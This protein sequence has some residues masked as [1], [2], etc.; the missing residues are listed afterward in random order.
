MEN[1]KVVV[2]AILIYI[3]VSYILIDVYFPLIE[4]T[5]AIVRKDYYKP[6]DILSNISLT[7]VIKRRYV[8]KYEDEIYK[9]ALNNKFA[10]LHLDMQALEEFFKQHGITKLSEKLLILEMCSEKLDYDYDIRI[11]LYQT[12]CNIC[13]VE[14]LLN[15][16]DSVRNMQ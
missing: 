14:K 9:Y 10:W 2:F 3:L 16:N 12:R 13:R 6:Y 11:I 5:K 4:V 15:L 1:P 8:K 7:G